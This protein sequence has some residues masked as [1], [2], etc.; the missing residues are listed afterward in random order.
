LP[1]KFIGHRSLTPF[2][3]SIGTRGHFGCKR[4]LDVQQA[5]LSMQPA[6]LLAVSNQTLWNNS[7]H[8]WRVRH[9]PAILKACFSRE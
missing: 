3:T 5:F 9:R 1:K 6:G 8:L 7:W 2:G 4:C